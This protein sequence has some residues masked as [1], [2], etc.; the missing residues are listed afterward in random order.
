MP[1]ETQSALPSDAADYARFERLSDVDYDRVNDF[2]RERVDFTA[3]EWAIARL[4]TDFRTKTGVEMTMIG[5]H[6]ADLVPFMPEPYSRQAVYQA[7][8]TFLDRVS[9]A[10]ATFL[11]GAYSGF[12]TAEE[13][14]EVTYEATEVAKFLLE[15]EGTPLAYGDELGTEERI[16]TAMESVHQASLALRYDRC[17]HCGGELNA[18]S[19]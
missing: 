19:D 4:C 5:Q 18:E 12:L 1:D 10:G 17:P 9:R 6:L 16:R 13:V 14:D 2:L 8:K 3:R 7:R 11:Y 15:V